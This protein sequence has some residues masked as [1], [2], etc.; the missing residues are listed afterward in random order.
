MAIDPMTGMETPDMEAPAMSLTTGAPA[1]DGKTVQRETPDVAEARKALVTQWTD[2]IKSAKTYWEPSFKRMREDMDFALGQQWSSDR[3]ETRYTANITL[4]MVAQKTSFLYAKNPKAVATRRERIM[5]TVWDGTQNQLQVAQQAMQMMMAPPMG[6]PGMAGMAPPGMPPQP[7]MPPDPS[8]GGGMPGMGMPQ[9]PMM[10]AGVSQEAMAIMQDEAQVRAHNAQMDAIGKTL[11]ILYGYNV[12]E[13]VHPFKQMMK[14]V[15]R[16]VITTGVGYVKLGFQR[17]MEKRPEIEARISDASEKLATLERLSAD[18]ADGEFDESS[19]EAEQLKLLVQD[20]ANQVDF[21][22]REGLVF[23]YPSAT[24]II[25]DTKCIHLREFLGGDWVTQEYILTTDQVQE[26]YGVD[27][28]KSFTAYTKPKSGNGNATIQAVMAGNDPR[29]RRDSKKGDCLV[30]EIYSRKDG[31]VYHICDGYPDFLRDPASPE[32]YIERF[33]PWF[34]LAFNE[35]EHEDEIFPPSDVRLMRDMQLEYN[36]SR[37]GLREHRIAARPF[38]AVAAGMLED[39]DI[40]KLENH[41]ANAVIELNGLQPQ[42]DIKS[43]LM[44]FSGPG[45]D[46]NLYEVNEVYTDVQRTTG[47]QEANL[48]GSSNGTA[49]ES[50]IAEASRQTSMGSNID[51]LDDLLTQLARAG[52]QILLKEVSAETVKRIVGPGAIWPEMS[53][54]EIAEELSLQ[55]EAGSTGKPNQAQ[56]IANAERIMPLLFQI[57]NIDPEWLAK[58]LLRRMNDKLDVQMAFKQSTPSITMMNSMKGQMTPG[59]GMAPGMAGGAAG[60]QNAPTAPMPGGSPAPDQVG[61]MTGAPPP[62]G[63]PFN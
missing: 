1:A 11:E 16:R 32:V 49:T 53:K 62:G 59:T 50:Q 13:Q 57:P 48:G 33:Y 63:M 3:N 18:M 25:P 28:G 60:A 44:P 21:V 19:A 26:I 51:D 29:N 4:R 42:Q 37:Q 45:I 54:Q 40:S 31:M 52:G 5:N 23:D 17:V 30:W 27:V 34:A 56:E 47:V 14:M 39:G 12:E 9:D 20:L 6:M 43:V 38:T 46:P 7:G 35:C 10:M 36:R 55:I 15:V 22:S 58:E 61:M 2:D 24:S 8:M 41:P